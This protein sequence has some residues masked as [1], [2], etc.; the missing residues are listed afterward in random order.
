M[1]GR[2][3]L[4]V[5]AASASIVALAF[6]ACGG[7]GGNTGGNTGGGKAGGEISIRGCTPENP[8]LPANTTEVCGGNLL[9]AVN[10]KLVHYNTETA[11]P[12]MDI[13]ESIDTSDSTNFTVKLKKGYKFHD[14]TEVK[15]KN[16]VGAW[17]FAAFG[18]NGQSNGSF[19]EPFD[20]Y[21]DVSDEKATIKE[22]KGLKV[23][24]DYT[25]TIKTAEPTSNLPIRLGYTAFAPLPDSVLGGDKAK[26]DEFG[27]KPIGAG[28][29]KVV[30]NSATEIT[31]EK[32]ADYSGASKPKVDKVHYRI[33]NDLSAAYNDVVANNLDFTDVVPPDQL[34]GDA[35]KAQLQGRSGSKQTGIIQ[36]LSFSPKDEQLK[37]VDM[38]IAISKAVDRALITKQIFF[39]NRT[40]AT[41]WV[42]PGV[43]GYKPGACGDNCVFD[44]AKAKELYDKVGGYKGTFPIAVNGDGGH[45]QWADAVCNQLRQNLGMDCQVQTTPDFKTL[46]K[47]VKARE[48]KGA[49]RGGW[50]MDYPSPENF[51]TPIYW[52]KA[53]SNDTDY[54]NPEWEAKMRQAA[55]AKSVEEGNKLYQEAE[56]M[57]A[58]DMPTMPQWYQASQFGYSDKV[59]NVKVTPFSTIDLTQVTVK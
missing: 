12:E 50:Q 41:G 20:G 10:A 21:S 5:A 36:V 9:D 44:K 33:Y 8:L 17:N 58:K 23:V 19:M 38:R 3:R 47:S 34:V 26:L 46:R 55:A 2:S 27:K 37:N 4:M 53:S 24:D 54:S 7:G 39:D 43:D 59:A 31:L 25:F 48:L 16:F 28:P 45:K 35:W 18:P 42:S 6:S 29:F 13:A 11:A 32:F 51:L 30:E 52:T 1:R 22:M 56:A 14:G 57:L 40:P 49:Y 15:A